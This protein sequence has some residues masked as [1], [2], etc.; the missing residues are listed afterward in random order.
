MLPASVLDWHR[1]ATKATRERSKSIAAKKLIRVFCSHEAV[2]DVIRFK[3][4]KIAI[5]PK[6]IIKKCV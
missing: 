1:G 3:F 2:Q 4:K 5:H 6:E